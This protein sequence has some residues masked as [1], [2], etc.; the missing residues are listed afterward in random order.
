MHSGMCISAATCLPARLV[1][2]KNAAGVKAVDGTLTHLMLGIL[3]KTSMVHA[4]PRARH[5][6]RCGL[7]VGLTESIRMVSQGFREHSA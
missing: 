6:T 7:A 5:V 4:V 2:D 3:Q 1:H